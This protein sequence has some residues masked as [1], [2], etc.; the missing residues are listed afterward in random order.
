VTASKTLD[1][2]FEETLDFNIQV[3]KP[4][5]KEASQLCAYRGLADTADASEKYAPVATSDESC[6]IPCRAGDHGRFMPSAAGLST[7]AANTGPVRATLRQGT[8]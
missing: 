3:E 1:R 7:R 4:I 8:P 5:V 6:A 2:G